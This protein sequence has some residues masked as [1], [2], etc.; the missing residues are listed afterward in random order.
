MDYQVKETVNNMCKMED[1]NIPGGGI[2]P[3]LNV[4]I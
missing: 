1:W 4:I 3:G 2:C